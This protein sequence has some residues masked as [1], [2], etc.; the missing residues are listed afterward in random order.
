MYFSV[1]QFGTLSGRFLRVFLFDLEQ[2]G[3]AKFEFEQW[4]A[5]KVHQHGYVVPIQQSQLHG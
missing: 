2:F 5:K 4:L 3:T 1:E